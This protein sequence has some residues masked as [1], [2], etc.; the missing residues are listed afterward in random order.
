MASFSKRGWK[1]RLRQVGWGARTTGVPLAVARGPVPRKRSASPNYRGSVN[2]RGWKPRLRR[3][4]NMPLIGA[5]GNRAYGECL[6]RLQINL[7]LTEPKV[8]LI[9]EFHDGIPLRARRIRNPLA[10]QGIGEL[11]KVLNK[12]IL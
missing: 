10:F 11:R 9:D 3:V 5:V 4:L 12:P 1:P 8:R 6:I 7:F 2:R